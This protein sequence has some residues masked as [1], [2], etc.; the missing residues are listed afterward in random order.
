MTLFSGLPDIFVSTFGQSVTMVPLGGPSY[1]VQGVFSERPV[2]ALGMVLADAA[3][4]IRDAD[5]GRVTDG[6]EVQV[7]GKTYFLRE[8]RPDGEGMTA[9]TLE[10][11][12]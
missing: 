5:V 8:P 3:L 6:H 1:E 9:Y 12:R 10:L 7:A 11:R 2:D 4:H